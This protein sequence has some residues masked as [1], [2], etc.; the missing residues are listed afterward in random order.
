MFITQVYVQIHSKFA[1][2]FCVFPM[3]PLLD[4]RVSSDLK[5]AIM[6]ARLDKKLTQAE[7]AK[8]H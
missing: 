3:F 5:K 7:L 2:L 1:V 6:Q 8:V 4:E